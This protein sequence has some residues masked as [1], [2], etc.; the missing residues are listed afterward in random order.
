MGGAT[1]T[2][3]VALLAPEVAHTFFVTISKDTRQAS[4][5]FVVFPKTSL[6]TY[7]RG[8]LERE[9]ASTC[10]SVLSVSVN[11][12]KLRFQFIGVMSTLNTDITMSIA[13]PQFETVPAIWTKG[14]S[15]FKTA[16]T[17]DDGT[18]Y[19]FYFPPSILR[20]VVSPNLQFTVSLYNTAADVTSNFVY[21]VPGN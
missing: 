20:S 5:S 17:L 4:G 21:S 1:W 16:V 19:T 9:C 14:T 3:D 12:I 7:P 15:D 8:T 6:P 11:D 2:M 18:G 10:P 13:S